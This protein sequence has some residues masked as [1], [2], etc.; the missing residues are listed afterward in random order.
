MKLSPR[1]G[2]PAGTEDTAIGALAGDARGC[3][4]AAPVAEESVA[5]A[6]LVGGEAAVAVMVSGR[7]LSR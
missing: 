3:F 2:V 5:A 1:S 6:G 7:R 4:P